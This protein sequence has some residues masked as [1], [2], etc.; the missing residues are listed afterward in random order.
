M[1]FSCDGS[2]WFPGTHIMEIAISLMQ[3]K[4]VE[5]SKGSLQRHHVPIA[6]FCPFPN[7]HASM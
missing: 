3:D 6:K 7:R 4:H 2:C 1:I 5:G